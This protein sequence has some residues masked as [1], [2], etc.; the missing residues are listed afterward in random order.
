MLENPEPSRS[1]N[2]CNICHSQRL[3]SIG[4]RD[5]TAARQNY[6]MWMVHAIYFQNC[7]ITS[8]VQ[9]RFKAIAK[10]YSSCRFWTPF[11][12]K[13]LLSF[14]PLFLA[15]P[16]FLFVLLF[17]FIFSCRNFKTFQ[18]P[19]IPFYFSVSFHDSIRSLRED[20]RACVCVCVCVCAAHV[21]LKIKVQFTWEGIWF[22]LTMLLFK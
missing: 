5:T 16:F 20:V 15:I 18:L 22:Q 12:F 7:C 2:I 14:C 21:H 13:N 9:F 19:V 1:K 8:T 10:Q 4:S 6:N 17:L 11:N 3:E